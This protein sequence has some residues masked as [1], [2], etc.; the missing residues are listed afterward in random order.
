MLLRL[1]VVLVLFVLA[2]IVA[3]LV[4]SV[5]YTDRTEEW[6]DAQIPR[7]VPGYRYVNDVK[8][9]PLTYSILV[10]FGIIGRTFLGQDGRAYEFLVIAGNTRRPFHDPQVCFS[11][12]GWAFRNNFQRKVN[13]PALGGDVPVTVLNLDKP[14]G[15]AVAMYFYRTPYRLYSSPT[16]MPFDMTFAKLA[17]RKNVDGQFFRFLLSPSGPDL[18]KD[19]AA[20]REFAQAMLEEIA[21]SPEGQYFINPN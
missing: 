14:G 13:I 2:G 12:Q 17:G 7:E 9:D 20:L 15:K 4:P 3:M 19:L 10:P 5:K 1:K 21:K 11:A 16:P 8:M 18:E 6:M